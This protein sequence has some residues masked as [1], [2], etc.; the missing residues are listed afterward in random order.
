MI[1]EFNST[2]IVGILSAISK[3]TG[4]TIEDG[5]IKAPVQL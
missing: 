3:A 4:S 1:L 5:V 2:S